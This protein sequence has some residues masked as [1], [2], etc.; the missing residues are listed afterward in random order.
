MPEH[1]SK[2]VPGSIVPISI[3]VLMVGY[4]LLGL[5]LLSTPEIG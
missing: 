3:A 1:K 5:W 4:T 2:T